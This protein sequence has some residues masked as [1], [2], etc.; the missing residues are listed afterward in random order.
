MRSGGG[1]ARFGLPHGGGGEGRLLLASFH[2]AMG[3]AFGGDALVW[4]DFE[5]K[6]KPK[7]FLGDF[8]LGARCLFGL[9]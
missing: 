4:P 1:K 6:R 3:V 2:R 7:P 9:F 5:A 8:F